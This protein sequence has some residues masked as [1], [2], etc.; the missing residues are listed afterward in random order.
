MGEA[1]GSFGELLV[2][3]LVEME[4]QP[5]PSRSFDVRRVWGPHDCRTDV[6]ASLAHW[7]ERRP[8]D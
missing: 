5:D 4:D 2:Q 1:G 8:M 6:L 3:A 7:T